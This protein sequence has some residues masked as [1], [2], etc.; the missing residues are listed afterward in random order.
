MIYGFSDKLKALRKAKHLTQAQ[1]AER[2]GISKST[3]SSYEKDI[4]DPSVSVLLD[5]CA[6][7]NV[8]SDYLLGL[9]NREF[10]SVE[11]LSKQQKEIVQNTI[12]AFRK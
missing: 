1:L 3:V 4:A 8:K 11:G 12:D 2:L 6:V 5:L 7:L 10:L 9:D